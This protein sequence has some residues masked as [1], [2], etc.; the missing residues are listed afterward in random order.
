MFR[1]ICQAKIYRDYKVWHE[2]SKNFFF[3]AMAIFTQVERFWCEFM[4][5]SLL[6]MPMQFSGEKSLG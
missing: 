3:Y 5:A 2:K 1:T 6:G 4:T